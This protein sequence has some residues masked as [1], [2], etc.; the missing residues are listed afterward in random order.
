MSDLEKTLGLDSA[1]RKQIE[2]AW[3]KSLFDLHGLEPAQADVMRDLILETNPGALPPGYF[4]DPIELVRGNHVLIGGKDHYAQ[5]LLM[6]AEPM[7]L[8]QAKM[9]MEE[10]V[11]VCP[12]GHEDG[13][14]R[15]ELVGDYFRSRGV[16]SVEHNI[17]MVDLDPMTREFEGSSL[18]KGGP[19][20]LDIQGMSENIGG[21]VGES[22]LECNHGHVWFLPTHRD[23]GI[24][25]TDH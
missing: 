8:E 12:E 1:L 7:T 14:L 10:G 2:D 20:T 23:I 16:S 5:Y 19:V 13:V 3:R 18:Q 6:G 24:N 22:V 4:F 11:V 15:E 21:Q 17:W 25:W 9:L